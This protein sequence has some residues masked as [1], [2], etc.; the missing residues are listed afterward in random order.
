VTAMPLPEDESQDQDL[1][2]LPVFTR[3]A[4]T[5]GVNPHAAA[6]RGLAGPTP[7]P[8]AVDAPEA[9]PP[10]ATPTAEEGEAVDWRRVASLR[11]RVSA[12]LN[13]R[14]E[15][16]VDSRARTNRLD[17]V[18]DREMVDL[19]DIERQEL[20]RQV[21]LEVID[22][23][24]R[25]S[26]NAGQGAYSLTYRD[27]LAQALFDEIFG[28]GRLQPLLRDE[29]VQ[30]IVIAGDSSRCFVYRDDGSIDPIPPIAES[31][32][33]LLDILSALASKGQ[34]GNARPF[35]PAVPDLH[36]RLQD[37]SRLA[38][39]SWIGPGVSA[40]IRCH[41]L[42][43]SDLDDLIA[44][45]TMTPLLG[46]FLAAAVRAGKNIIISGDQGS[47]KTTLMRALCGQIPPW[48]SL[49]T[50]ETNAE[51]FLDQFPERHWIVHA[52]EERPGMGEVGADGQPAGTYSL[53]RALV[54]SQRMQADRTLVGEVRGPEIWVLIK[55]LES[56]GG[57][58]CTTHA[59]RAD[60]AIE[61]LVT[62]AMEAGSHVTA[63]LA[64]LKLASV[65][66]LVV[67]LGV[68]R[69]PKPGGGGWKLD[70]WV[71]EVLAVG[72]GESG[73][74]LA[75]TP[76]FKT[77]PGSRV[78]RPRTLPDDLRALAEDGFDVT[79]F[80]LEGTIEESA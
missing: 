76:V 52:F 18:R 19:S 11:R 41:R 56:G 74:G 70:H 2:D 64:T 1:V 32:E 80:T 21:I 46:S 6:L 40:V 57:G 77:D 22:E 30:N 58:M 67:Q 66:D 31:N 39:F 10:S 51:L 44:R 38:A 9:P 73:A 7:S 35:S 43:T 37:G 42:R 49:A 55:T 50:I 3:R 16:L 12:E 13:R 60:K 23:D 78:A 29:T 75:M 45:G 14:I 8:A 63:D 53:A 69:E 17:A 20:G 15:S 68:K 33:D 65:V 27:R 36:L 47:G 25:D 48:V 24:E 59:V 28:L 4:A 54:T 62:C 61:K 34:G 26:T 5:P 72:P 79:A 71:E